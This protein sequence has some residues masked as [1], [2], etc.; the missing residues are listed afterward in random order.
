VPVAPA[1]GEIVLFDGVCGLCNRFVDFLLS[2]DRSDV[3]RF[4]ALQSGPGRTVLERFQMPSDYLSSIVF[5][6]GPRVFRDSTAAIKIL[7]SLG[8][9]WKWVEVFL[10][11]PPPFRDM[12]YEWIA[13]HRYQWFGKAQTCRIPTPQEQLKFLQES[14]PRP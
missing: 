1:A 3:L 9:G 2:R 10:L 14:P 7:G 8:R 6:S 13:G 5:V 12:V 4:A 11:V